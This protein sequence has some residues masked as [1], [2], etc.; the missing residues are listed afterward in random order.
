MDTPD[1]SNRLWQNSKISHVRYVTFFIRVLLEKSD[2]RLAVK[3]FL[4]IFYFCVFD[5]FE[6]KVTGSL[7]KPG[8]S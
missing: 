3:I 4:F 2:W 6:P 5:I 1:F 7:P 8:P